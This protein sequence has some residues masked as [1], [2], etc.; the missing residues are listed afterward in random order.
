MENI[1][2]IRYRISSFVYVCDDVF[3]LIFP[4]DPRNILLTSNTFECFCPAPFIVYFVYK[5]KVVGDLTK[6]KTAIVH[7]SE[8]TWCKF[9]YKEDKP[10]YVS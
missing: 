1:N 2:V 8:F 10:R 3:V 4:A 9:S 6:L 7:S 5:I